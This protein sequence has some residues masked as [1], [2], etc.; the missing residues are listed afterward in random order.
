MSASC[1]FTAM[2]W[3]KKRDPAT[4]KGPIVESMANGSNTVVAWNMWI[5]L[6]STYLAWNPEIALPL[7]PNNMYQT[8]T[9]NNMATRVSATSLSGDVN[10][11]KVGNISIVG[12]NFRLVIG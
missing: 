7:S 8:T 4:P 1:R 3:F 6:S 5:H 12:A 10:G 9:W 2:I 11:T